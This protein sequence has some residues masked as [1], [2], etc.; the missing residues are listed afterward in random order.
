MFRV[1][2]IKSGV[3]DISPSLGGFRRY[4]YYLIKPF[5]NT[6]HYMNRVFYCKYVV[7]NILKPSDMI[8]GMSNVPRIKSSFYIDLIGQYNIP[9]LPIG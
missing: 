6:E 3:R 1:S 8:N 7:N 4:I 5:V 2:V 9:H